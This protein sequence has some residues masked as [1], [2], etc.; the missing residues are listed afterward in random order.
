MSF[1][2]KYYI[3]LQKCQKSKLFNYSLFTVSENRSMSKTILQSKMNGRAKLL[4]KLIDK[5]SYLRKLKS[6]KTNILKR[7]VRYPSSNLNKQ[8][9]NLTIGGNIILLNVCGSQNV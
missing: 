8:S 7:G 1:V 9:L 4:Y 6:N 2:M 3:L 5:D